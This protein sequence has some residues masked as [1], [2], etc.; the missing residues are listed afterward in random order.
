M[1]KVVSDITYDKPLNKDDDQDSI[2][3]A[4]E[5]AR[6][7]KDIDKEVRGEDEDKNKE[8]DTLFEYRSEDEGSGTIKVDSDNEYSLHLFFICT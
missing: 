2:F 4:A 1:R 7:M 5:I 6:L 8:D 3:E